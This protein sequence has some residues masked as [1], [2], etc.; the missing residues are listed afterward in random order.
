MDKYES[1]MRKIKLGFG[2]GL[3]LI[4][5]IPL[6]MFLALALMILWALIS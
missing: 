2:A 4:A 1:E 3:A 5:L 6:L